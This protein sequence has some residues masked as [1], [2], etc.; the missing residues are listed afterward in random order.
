MNTSSNQLNLRII[1]SAF[2]IGLFIIGVST[3]RAYSEEL[4][5]EVAETVAEL[6]PE[7]DNSLAKL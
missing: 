6:L 5:E 7:L 1:I 3:Y 4:K 2:L